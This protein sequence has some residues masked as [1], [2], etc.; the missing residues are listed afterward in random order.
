[1]SIGFLFPGQG[2]Q[3]SGMFVEHFEEYPEFNE[4]FGLG[5]EF[6]KENLKEVIFSDDG[7]LDD[8][9]YTQPIL[10]LA[11]FSLFKIWHKRGCALPKV[12]CGHSLGEI[13]SLL[14][15]GI[16]SLPDALKFIKF[17]ASFMIESKGEKKT[18]MTAVLGLNQSQVEEVIQEL[19]NSFL[20]VV[21]INSPQQVV[22]AGNADE[23][24]LVKPKLSEIGSRRQI[25]LT[26]S[27]PSHS[28]LMNLASAKLKVAI[29]EISLEEPSFPT[30]HNIDG[31]V[32]QKIEDIPEKL[33]QQISKPVQWAESMR[34]LKKYGLD[35]FVE[36][37]PG[38]ILTGLAKQNKI[39]S[40]FFQSDSVEAF[41]KLLSMYGK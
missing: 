4:I 9:Y 41:N 12:S 40:D 27:V 2:S 28:S 19:K 34:R 35:A 29:E 21:N 25:D 32:S 18:K 17:R 1:M 31:K 23:I 30:I 3:Y 24:E 38:K 37:G 7:R 11:S 39:K 5:S 6:Y 20:E 36:F 14:C 22:I 13:S 16:I 15:A 26:V 10:M 8:T 33:S